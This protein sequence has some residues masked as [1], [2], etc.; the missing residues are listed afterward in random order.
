MEGGFQ[1]RGDLAQTALPEIFYTIDRFQVPGLIEAS[2]DG[3]VKQVYIKDGNVVH[4]TSNDRGDSLGSFLQRHALLTQEQ[5]EETMRERERTQERYGALLVTRGLLSPAQV[6]EA[7]RK[8][9]EA[10]V[11]SLFYWKDGSVSF[12]IG[13]FGDPAVVKIQLPMRQVVLQGIKRAPDAKP[14]VARLGPRQTVFEACYRT[15]ELIATALDTYD[16]QLLA[17][18]NGER[19]LY[20]ICAEGPRT[21]ADN[22]KVL[23]AL[24]VLRLI[25]SIGVRED[26]PSSKPREETG[27]AIKI[28]FRTEGGSKYGA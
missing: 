27:N 5:F 2:R 14:V 25:R 11:W 8:Q 7:I 17:L 24:Q 18:V 12:R 21:A 23:Y 1:Y 20:D 10:I 9:T 26:A 28:R 4:A 19:T 22:G 3:I 16:M 6:Y 13:E 15:E